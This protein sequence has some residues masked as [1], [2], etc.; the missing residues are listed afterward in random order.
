[1][2]KRNTLISLGLGGVVLAGFAADAVAGPSYSGAAGSVASWWNYQANSGAVSPQLD[3]QAIGETPVSSG[4]SN[5]VTSASPTGKGATNIGAS[6][7]TGTGSL[8]VVSVDASGFQ[9]SGSGSNDMSY[10]TAPTDIQAIGGNGGATFRVNYQAAVGGPDYV[11]HLNGNTV[12]SDYVSYLVRLTRFDGATPVETIIAEHLWNGTT[13]VGAAGSTIYNDATFPILAGHNYEFYV[14][15]S[16]TP[17]QAWAASGYATGID[18][19][20]FNL[21]GTFT[22]VPEPAMG[23]MLLGAGL[24][25]LYRGRRRA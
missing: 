9:A 8:A 3:Y 24:G 18:S 7:A 22:P 10:D 16:T 23:V 1:M 19:A 13:F 5:S 2:R 11:L 20:S 15:V 12:V 21:T 25:T 14:D 17:A 4:W 6:A